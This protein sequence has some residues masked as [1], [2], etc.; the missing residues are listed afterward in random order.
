MI[1]IHFN[2]DEKLY[3]QIYEHFVTEIKSNAIKAGEKLPSERSLKEH[4]K[5]SLN[6]V[7]NAYQQLLDEGYIVS[8]ERSGYFVDKI[9]YKD[10]TEVS[11]EV[12]HSVPPSKPGY[13][14]NFSYTGLDLEQAPHSILKKCAQAGLETALHINTPPKEGLYSLRLEIAKY[15]KERRGVI[16]SP[17]HIIITNGLSESFFIISQLLNEKVYAI[18]DPGYTRVEEVLKI[19]HK[20]V[21]NIPID[22]YGFSVKDLEKTKAKLVVVSPN[23]Q[24]PTGIMM[25]VRRRMRLLNWAR[26][27]QGRY[28]IE[29]DYN[30][31]FKYQG[32]PIPAL[33]SMDESKTILLGSFSKIVGKFLSVSYLVLPSGLLEHAKDINPP[34]EVS[35]LQQCTLEQFMK[36]GDFERHLN[37]MNTHYR[38]KRSLLLAKVEQAEGIEILGSDAGLHLVIRMDKTLYTMEQFDELMSKHGIYAEKVSAYSH[39][40]CHDNEVILGFGAIPLRDI[41]E[42]VACFLK[43]LR[44]SKIYYN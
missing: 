14:Y 39:R 31:D 22:R 1:T 35:L 38:K 8:K 9:D 7:K 15:L 5:V 42:G 21:L 30:S 18:E 33:K 40:T 13:R 25:G 36:N 43:A 34:F 10:F 24:F 11:G 29:D 17:D 3:I 28:I 44:R 41:E 6:T 27:K 32:K 19:L 26:E 37:R 16:T 2:E 12:P 4:L 23:H 20:E